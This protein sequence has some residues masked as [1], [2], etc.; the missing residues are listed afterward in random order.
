MA[1]DNECK[2]FYEKLPLGVTVDI[3]LDIELRL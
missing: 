1:V 2:L 3:I